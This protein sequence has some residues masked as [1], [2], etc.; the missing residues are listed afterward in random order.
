MN[1]IRTLL[2]SFFCATCFVLNAQIVNLTILVEGIKQVENSNIMIALYNEKDAFL[3]QDQIFKKVEVAADSAMVEYTFTGL[4]HGIYAISLY[5]D[6]DDDNEMDRKW[7]GP[8]KEG[9]GFS[10]NFTSN[11]RPAR[12][13]DASFE[14]MEDKII[15]IKVVY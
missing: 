1:L 9:Y 6:E 8:P 13:D 4:Q 7:Y 12:F 14:L 5:H 3:D 10:N 15:E 2:L 11:I